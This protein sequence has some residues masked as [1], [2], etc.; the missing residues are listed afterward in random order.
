MIP[1]AVWRQRWLAIRARDVQLTRADTYIVCLLVCTMLLGMLMATVSWYWAVFYLLLLTLHGI[2]FAVLLRRL[3]EALRLD[4]QE[5]ALA[6]A[7]MIGQHIADV[8][9]QQTGMTAE[10][11]WEKPNMN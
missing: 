7:T 9:A 11:R 10:V 6:T 8:I 5:Q 2:V 3:A 4:R 1:F